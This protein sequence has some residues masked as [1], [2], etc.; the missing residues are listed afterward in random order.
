MFSHGYQKA[1]SMR[2][3]F[4]LV[5]LAIVLVIIGLIVGGILVGRDLIV[6]ATVNAQLAQYQKFDAAASTFRTKYD[7]LPGDLRVPK[8]TQFNLSNTGCTGA[9]GLRDGND[10]IEDGFSPS[11]HQGYR[12]PQLFWNDLSS[13]KLINHLFPGPTATDPSCAGPANADLLT[14]PTHIINFLPEARI[15]QSNYIYVNT[16][17]NRNWYGMSVVSSMTNTCMTSAPGLRVILASA[18]DEKLDDGLATSGVVRAAYISCASSVQIP[19][20]AATHGVNTCYETTSGV[21]STAI[22]GGDRINCALMVRMQ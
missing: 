1:V 13:A 19:S 10:L 12:E 8:A 15:G 4:T 5:E 2:K 17:N 20:N 21:Y 14:G 6:T 11:Y 22:E 3:G 9:R 16:W 18:I 7:G